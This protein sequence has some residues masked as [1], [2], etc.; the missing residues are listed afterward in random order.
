[1]SPSFYRHGLMVALLVGA[2]QGSPRAQESPSLPRGVCAILGLPE[3]G[4]ADSVL[5]MVRDGTRVYF[6]TPVAADLA[7]VRR[8]ADHA[9][10]LGKAV[11]A[12][13]GD[14][15][16]IHLA[17]NIAD[18]VIVSPSARQVVSHAEV[19]RVLCPEGQAD[20]DGV[21]LFKPMP[22][23]VDAWPQ[24]FH[25]PDNNPQSADQLART[26]YL[27][28]FLSFPQFCPMPEVTVAAGG[29]L[30]KAFGHIA[31]KANQN[32]ALNTL[33]AVNG[34]NGAILWT[35]PLREGFM[36]HRNTW[37]ATA[38]ALYFGDDESCKA[39][40]ARTGKLV[41]EIVVPD[42]VGDG[43]VWKWMSLEA[44][45]LCALVGGEE[46]RP[47]TQPSGVLGLGHWP[48]GLWEGHEYKD[49]KSNFGY[50]RTFLAIQPASGRILWQHHEQDYIDG[51]GVCMK[52]GRI[53][54]YSP[55][56]F[57]ACLDAKGGRVLWRNE[58]ADL[59][60]AIGPPGRAQNPTQ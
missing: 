6:Q 43:K 17:D 30:F 47:K 8:A 16:R 26:P 50:G 9:G 59:L 3:P 52:N 46:V 29:R 34:Y 42:G 38:D 2:L 39:L 37:I 49:P 56:K 32:A 24:P 58:D 1:M 35:R 7:A 55:A 45:V 54:Y 36:I 10:L 18:R 27:T 15:A 23:G 51:R 13:L 31:H 28:Q 21:R 40:D 14:F 25:G 44:G 5:T 20:L 48:W 60:D 19:L 22:A 57:L 11:F 12:D 53:Y 41:R 4:R 33:M